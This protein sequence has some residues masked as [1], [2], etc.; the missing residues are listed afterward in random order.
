M[1]LNLITIALAAA[2]AGMAAPALARSAASE[3]AQQVVSLKDGSTVYVFKDGKMGMADQFGRTVRMNPGH[4]M[5]ARD[6]QKIVMTGDEVARLH[7]LLIQGHL[8]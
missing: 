7:T 1:K 8:N 3:A 5:E 6:G 4:V 2:I